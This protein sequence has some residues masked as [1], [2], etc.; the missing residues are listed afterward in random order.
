[1]G[2]V[3]LVF[4]ALLSISW[5]ARLQSQAH[6]AS[7]LKSS[8]LEAELLKKHIQ[9][10]F[11]MNTLFTIISLIEENPKGAI[12]LIKALAAEFRMINKISSNKV[13]TL[14]EEIELCQKHLELMGFRRSANYNLVTNGICLEDIIP[15][16]IFLTLIEN[17]LTHSYEAYENGNFFL[18][19]KKNDYQTQ[20]IL[21]NDGSKINA[22]IAAGN[23]RQ[24][25]DGMGMRYI[26]ARL[27]ENFSG[28]WEI[29]YGK[30][31][32]LWEVKITIN[33]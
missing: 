4:C 33:C 27:E 16:M 13:I 1:L 19:C 17:G 12:K 24:I 22:F 2:D 9:P 10:H 32:G 23:Q 6:H 8:R 25:E 31:N 3:I 21:K 15:P 28:H 7:I 30:K 18:S 26:K 29:D 11:I 14:K 5:Q 20:Y